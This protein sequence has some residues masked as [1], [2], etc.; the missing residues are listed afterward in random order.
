MSCPS[1]IPAQDL[2]GLGLESVVGLGLAC[3]L[4]VVSGLYLWL[5]YLAKF[6]EATQTRRNIKL[7]FSLFARSRQTSQHTHSKNQA[8]KLILIKL[9]A[10]PIFN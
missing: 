2:G 6:C 5:F 9:R 8:V 4:V 10:G 7:V 3:G 1:F